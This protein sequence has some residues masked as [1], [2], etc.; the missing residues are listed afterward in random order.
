MVLGN[1]RLLITII[2]VHVVASIGMELTANEITLHDF[3]RSPPE[4]DPM[5]SIEA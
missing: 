1:K 2:H 3:T 4:V 5:K